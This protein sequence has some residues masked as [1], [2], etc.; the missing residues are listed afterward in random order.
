[1]PEAFAAPS[2]RPRIP[3]EASPEKIK[4]FSAQGAYPKGRNSRH[5]HRQGHGAGWRASDSG[6]IPQ[7]EKKVCPILPQPIGIF[8]H[9]GIT[10]ALACPALRDD[11]RSLNV[12]IQL[13]RA[14]ILHPRTL[15]FYP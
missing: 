1:V 3:A 6:L 15:M 4:V 14:I 12:L 9:S 8:F 10:A 13:L 5:R 11:G 2:L 7:N